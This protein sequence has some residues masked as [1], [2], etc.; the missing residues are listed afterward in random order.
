MHNAAE[1]RNDAAT[2]QRS[3]HQS[4]GEYRRISDQIEHHQS[5]HLLPP[6]LWGTR[7][8]IHLQL[9]TLFCGRHL[10][11]QTS[12]ISALKPARQKHRLAGPTLARR[13]FCDESVVTRS[14]GTQGCE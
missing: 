5:I 13:Y 3:Q 6:K 9:G 4:A 14:L 11:A 8:R 12:L 10:V 2:E 1:I 7:S